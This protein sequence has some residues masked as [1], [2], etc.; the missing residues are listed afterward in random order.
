MRACDNPFATHR[1][2]RQRYRLS[3]PEWSELLSRAADNRYRGAIVGAHGSGKTTL[4]EDL[5]QRLAARG[6]RVSTVTLRAERR[7]LPPLRRFGLGEMVLCDGAEQ[8]SAWDAMRLRWLTRIAEG[9]IVT[10]HRAAGW[11]P[12]LHEC[13]T[14]PELLYGLVSALGE[15]LSLQESQ[16]LLASH[17]GNVRSALRELYDSA[18]RKAT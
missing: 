9:L 11:G 6:W 12:I 4:L 13:T 10:T 18:G 7:R 1:V 8:L 5:G 2:L 15:R 3:E 16:E 17:A 14:S